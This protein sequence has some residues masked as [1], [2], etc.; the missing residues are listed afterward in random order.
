MNA[1]AQ[2]SLDATV[3]VVVFGEGQPEY[4]P[5][6]ALLYPDGT[7]LIEWTFTEEERHRIAQG[8]TIRHW[9]WKPARQQCAQ[10]GAITPVP[11]QPQQLEVT[12]E[13]IT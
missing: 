11:L 8:E 12:D 9:I 3:A 7:I 2:I 1:I 10:C 5:L 6:P 4:T 13:R